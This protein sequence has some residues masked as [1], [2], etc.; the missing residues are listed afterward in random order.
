MTRESYC[1][2]LARMV[3]H[4]DTDAT[5][6]RRAFCLLSVGFRS[7][8]LSFSPK[9]FCIFWSWIQ[10]VFLSR[11]SYLMDPKGFRIFFWIQVSS[12]GPKD[13][14]IFRA[15]HIFS[16]PFPPTVCPP[17]MSHKTNQRNQPS[18]ITSLDADG[19]RPTAD[20]DA[21]SIQQTDGSH[22]YASTP[23]SVRSPPLP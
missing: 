19:R 20:E 18:P 5:R 6:C 7:V 8:R 9:L 16:T 10:E 11:F 23:L 4:A 14:R 2:S 22:K 12:V 3:V 1:T 15:R 13:F 21:S 17:S